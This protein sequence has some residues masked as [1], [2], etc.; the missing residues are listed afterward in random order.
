M[1]FCNKSSKYS[2]HK[3]FLLHNKIVWIFSVDIPVDCTRKWKGGLYFCVH[4]LPPHQFVRV[5]GVSLMHFGM[6][7]RGAHGPW[8]RLDNAPHSL[9]YAA[10]DRLPSR[11]SQ[12]VSQCAFRTRLAKT[13]VTSPCNLADT[14]NENSWKNYNSIRIQPLWWIKVCLPKRI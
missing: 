4:R 8:G 14:R 2:V 5:F 11:P 7:P 3:K 6:G 1:S 13:C 12:S 10:T 9:R